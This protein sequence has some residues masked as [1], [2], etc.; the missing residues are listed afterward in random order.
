MRVY[1]A[2]FQHPQYGVWITAEF[3]DNRLKLDLMDDADGDFMK[4]LEEVTT[5]EEHTRNLETYDQA[6]QW[7]KQHNNTY[8]D[9][10]KQA[11]TYLN[12]LGSDITF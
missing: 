12:D 8:F 3:D 6:K 4:Q 11:E 2:N 5:P 7:A 9:S 1:R 10:A